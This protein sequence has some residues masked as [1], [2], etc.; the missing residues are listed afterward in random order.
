MRKEIG[1]FIANSMNPPIFSLKKSNFNLSAKDEEKSVLWLHCKDV[2]QAREDV[3]FTMKVEGAY[4]E[5]LER[6]LMER[7]RISNFQGEWLMNR[8]NE[9]GGIRV[10][11]TQYRRWGGGQ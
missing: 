8:R 2:H 7:V 9:M 1:G 6:Q 3:K 11:R 4:N 10:E 5:A